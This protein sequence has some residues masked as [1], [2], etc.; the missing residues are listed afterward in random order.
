MTLTEI[1]KINKQLKK[2]FSK[3]SFQEK[4][5]IYNVEGEDKKIKSVSSLIKY[6]YEEFDTFTVSEKWGKERLINPELVR[7]AWEGE[8][9][10]ANTH[11]TN[12]HLV[13]EQ[14]GYHKYFKTGNCP[15]IIDKQ[16]LGCIEFFDNLPDYLIPVAFELQMYSPKYWFC[17]TAD[18]ILFNTKNK[19]YYVLDW[20]T[21]KT[22]TDVYNKKS[23]IG[24]PNEYK[25]L[26][27]NL[28]KYNLQLNFYMYMLKEAGFDVGGA[29]IIHLREDKKNKKLYSTH[30]V[31]P[32]L[33]FIEDWLKT[34]VHL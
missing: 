19:K 23:L 9:L 22:L 30:R 17:G 14:Y 4:G 18:I 8:G 1:K 6:F 20:K 2:P 32:I 31:K 25:L 13:G 16:S 28:G 5:H 21:N 3:L 15:K 33:G 24:V 29:V 12:V 34:G 26:Q 10:I 27:N 11:G 7:E